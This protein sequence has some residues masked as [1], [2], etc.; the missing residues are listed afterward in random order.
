MN[1]GPVKD[2][3]SRSTE[4]IIE[5]CGGIAAGKT[6]FASLMER[7]ELDP[8]YE[9]F[10]NSPF[11][12]AFY[13]N[14]G[15]HIFETEI[16]F[17]L[18]HYHQ[19][20]NALESK[21]RLICDFSFFLDLAYARIGLSGGK[22]KAFECVFEEIS[23][24][25]PMPDLIVHLECAAE[26]E[27]ERIRKRARAEEASINLEFLD[28]LNTAVS[29]EVNTIQKTIPVITIDSSKKDFANHE[30]VKEEMVG[31]ITDF[32]QRPIQTDPTRP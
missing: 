2:F 1:F 17:I 19:I 21:G 18:L 9:N 22:L 10:K 16:S 12:E 5:V 11:W 28:S 27:L 3:Q 26:T 8:I 13:S 20:K 24:E 14:P 29:R 30:S 23:K 6:T 7:I 4:I 25:L 32:L 31:L 15:K